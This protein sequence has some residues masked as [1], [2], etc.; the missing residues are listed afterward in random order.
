MSQTRP[1][2]DPVGDPCMKCGLAA[3]TH[4][5]RDRRAY[6][7][8]YDYYMRDT[9]DRHTTSRKTLKTID[10]II[11]ID[12]EGQGRKPHK[13]NFLAG[14][15]ELGRTWCVRP[16]KGKALTTRQSL[17][18]LLSLPSRSLVVGFAFQY[19]LTKILKDIPDALLLDLFHEERRMKLIDKFVHYRPIKW[20]PKNSYQ[21]YKINYM[22]RKFTV[23]SNGQKVTVWDIFRFFQG[24]FTKAL[25]DWNIGSKE[26]IEAM[27]EMKEKRSEFDKLDRKSIEDY[28]F[29]ECKHLATLARSVINAHKDVGLELKHYYGAGSTASAL[30]TKI[31]IKDSILPCPNKMKHAVACAFFGGRFENSCVGKVEGTIYNYDISSAYPYQTTFLP[32]LL[33]GTWRHKTNPRISDIERASLALIHWRLPPSES[34]KHNGW[35]PFPIRDPKGSIVFPKAALG[36]WCWKQEYLAAAKLFSNVEHSEA[37]LYE[38]Q[39]SCQPFNSIPYYYNERCKLGKDGKGIVLKLGPNSVY[40]KL[41]Q[42]KGLNPPF[43]CWIWAGN[44]TSGCRAQLLSSFT[45]IDNLW[46]ILMFATDGVSSKVPL[47]LPK[48]VDTGTGGTGKPLG[49]WEEKIFLSGVFC[50]RPGIHFPLNPTPEQMKEVRARGLGKKVLYENWQKIIDCWERDGVNGIH[51][52]H[53]NRFIGAKSALSIGGKTKIVKRSPLYGE[54]VDYPIN[55]TFNPMPKRRGIA[56]DGRLLLHENLNWESVPYKAALMNPDQIA[57]EKARQISEEQPDHNFD[58]VELEDELDS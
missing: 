21:V 37:F 20:I 18:F 29:E 51:T 55:V 54:W 53:A 5:K 45:N 24:K 19:D 31:N 15:D 13:Y 8:S 39:C 49:G 40:G 9:S 22:N 58:D 57:Y 42:S 1:E 34:T 2:H 7:Q 43:Q 36:G 27:A 16:D 26:A 33:H 35:G 41:A 30:L 3:F 44:I 48:P 47:V 50:V 4:R 28:C 17:D 10:R 12:G 6:Y 56:K 14:A 32:C 23:Q 11:G 46:Y 38:T 52:I 25:I